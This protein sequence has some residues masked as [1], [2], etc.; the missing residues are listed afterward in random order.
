MGFFQIATGNTET[1]SCPSLQWASAT[2][3]TATTTA[4]AAL[5]KPTT[6]AAATTSNAKTPPRCT[7]S[8]TATSS[9][10]SFS[11]ADA[12]AAAGLATRS[13]AGRVGDRLQ[14]RARLQR[15]RPRGPKDA[16]QNGRSNSLGGL[17]RSGDKFIQPLLLQFLN[18]YCHYEILIIRFQDSF[19]KIKSGVFKT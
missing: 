18:L 13:T 2:T 10:G 16:D 12:N 1:S 9:S 17:R 6:A 5:D 14:R 19:V 3:T 7:S 4:A 8:A 11:A 15:E